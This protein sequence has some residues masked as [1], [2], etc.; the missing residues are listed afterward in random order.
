MF[1]AA[2]MMRLSAV[3]LEKD[4]RK[5]LETLGGMGVVQLTRLPPGVETT[6]LR[7]RDGG[8]EIARYE[9]FWMRIEESRR[10]LEV[11]VPTAGEPP[12]GLVLSE[13]DE[14]L[15]SIEE[16][17]GEVSD[18]RRAYRQRQREMAALCDQVSGYRGLDVPLDSPDRFSF[19]HFVTGSLPTE[20]LE[21]LRAELGDNVAL[22]T[23]EGPKGRQPVIAMTTRQGSGFLD[24]ALQKAGF[25]REALPEAEGATVDTLCAEKE[26]EH[27]RLESALD[28][29]DARIRSLSDEF[30][31]YLNG[32]ETMIGMELGLLRAQQALSRTE[33]T[34]VIAGWIPA[35]EAPGV[36]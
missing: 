20:N 16:H 12:A 33:A 5:V 3:I 24:E 6:A 17:I 10:L 4:E 34:S 22:V 29:L 11:P 35:D 18:L 21:S 8:A 25:Q 19:L 28:R 7:V 26:K 9:H 36:G 2:P 23:L 13:V 30:G 31:P 32:M 1:S 15:R 14:R 27:Q